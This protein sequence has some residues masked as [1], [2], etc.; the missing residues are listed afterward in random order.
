[1]KRGDLYRVSHPS[2]DTKRQR[3]VV[4]ISRQRL[5]ETR[6]S[7]VVCAPVYTAY[8]GLGTQVPIGIDEGLKHTSSIHCDAIASVLRSD[9]TH[10]IGSLGPVKIKELNEAIKIALEIP[11]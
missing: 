6:Y 3:V 11:D 2:N 9:L 5:L 10:Y 7:L 4:V 8:E 1:M